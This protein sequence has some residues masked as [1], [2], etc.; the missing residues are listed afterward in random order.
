MSMLRDIPFNEIKIDRSF[1]ITDA[2]NEVFLRKMIMMKHIVGLSQE[3]GMTCI[4]EGA[5]TVDQVDLLFKNGCTRV[6]G[7][8]FDK[9]MPVQAFGARLDNPRYEQEHSGCRMKKKKAETPS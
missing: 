4:A 9:P 1:L 2:D 7:Y 6:Q 5:E 3:L 8:F